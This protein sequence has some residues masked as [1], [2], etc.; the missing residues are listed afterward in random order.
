M[1]HLKT[2]VVISKH[3]LGRSET[4]RMVCSQAEW[5]Q[6]QALQP[7]N[8]VLIQSGFT[9]EAEAERLARG[10]AGDSPPLPRKSYQWQGRY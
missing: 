7:G 5:D 3:L 8:Q 4:V 10:T 6:M 9:N 1:P 2:W